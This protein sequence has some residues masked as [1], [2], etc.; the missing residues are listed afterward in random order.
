[1]WEGPRPLKSSILFPLGPV[2]GAFNRARED[3]LTEAESI[4]RQPTAPQSSHQNP[5]L[6]KSDL[7]GVFDGLNVSIMCVPDVRDLEEL[8]AGARVL[9]KPNLNCGRERIMLKP[10]KKNPTNQPNPGHSKT[11]SQP[12][13]LTTD[14]RT[15]SPSDPRGSMDSSGLRGLSTSFHLVCVWT[16]LD[17]IMR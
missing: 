4:E 17:S 16:C 2:L 8:A 15:S 5:P 12:I 3:G 6:P 9:V 1:M 10:K 14:M 11:I 7:P 13:Y